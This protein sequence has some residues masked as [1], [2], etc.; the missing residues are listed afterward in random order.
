MVKFFS[1]CTCYDN[2]FQL[3]LVLTKKTPSDMDSMIFVNSR[4][5]KPDGSV[6]EEDEC[7]G[8]GRAP[9]ESYLFSGVPTGRGRALNAVCNPERGTL[10]GEYSL[11]FAAAII[12][13]AATSTARSIRSVCRFC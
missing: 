12:L 6:S 1:K 13:L 4:Y 8:A 7:D 2:R 5:Q 9:G 3:S 11:Q 10:P